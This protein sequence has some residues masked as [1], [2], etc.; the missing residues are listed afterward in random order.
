MLLLNPFLSAHVQSLIDLIQTRSVVQYV[1]PFSSVRIEVMAQAFAVGIEEMSRQ[2]EKLVEEKRV[3]GKIDLID[4]VS[5]CTS[6]QDWADTG[7]GTGDEGARS[8]S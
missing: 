7:L 1:A 4:L 5:S 3:L 2:V 6:T 8:E